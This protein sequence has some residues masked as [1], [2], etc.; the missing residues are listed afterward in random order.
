LEGVLND[1]ILPLAQKANVFFLNLKIRACWEFV[2][3]DKKD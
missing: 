2:F 3:G 1:L